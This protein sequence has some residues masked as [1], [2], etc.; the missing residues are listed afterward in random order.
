MVQS[1]QCGRT[2]CTY[3][4]ASSAL[5]KL[6]CADGDAN[7]DKSH[8]GDTDSADG[9]EGMVVLSAPLDRSWTSG[10][11]SEAV[12]SARG[13]QLTRQHVVDSSAQAPCLHRTR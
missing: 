11:S 10:W 12:P 3:S 8:V 4:F 13:V 6:W 9:A 5:N 1:G 7:D 2:R